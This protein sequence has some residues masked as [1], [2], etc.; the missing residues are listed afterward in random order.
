MRLTRWIQ[1]W[2]PGQLVVAT[3]A[4]GLLIGWC[5]WYRGEIQVQIN[6]TANA[7][8][9]EC[10]ALAPDSAAVAQCTLQEIARGMASINEG[11]RLQERKALFGWLAAFLI[12]F[13]L[14]IL[15]LWFSERARIHSSH[16]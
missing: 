7:P 13:E 11:F 3:T 6:A 2:H 1:R 14:A 5:L 15:W 8:S 10:E 12:L 16:D 4:V 9:F